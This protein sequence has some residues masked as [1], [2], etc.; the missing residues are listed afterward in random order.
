[1]FTLPDLVKPATDKD[2]NEFLTYADRPKRGII[3]R[4]IDSI[5]VLC[6]WQ[7]GVYWPVEGEVNAV[8]LMATTCMLN[9]TRRAA[10]K[11]AAVIGNELLVQELNDQIQSELDGL[12]LATDRDESE[13]LDEVEKAVIDQIA[14]NDALFS[15]PDLAQDAI[16]NFGIAFDEN[17]HVTIDKAIYAKA[18]DAAKP[19]L[20][21]A[22]DDE[23][24]KDVPS[25]MR[26]KRVLEELS[27][28]EDE[29][30]TAAAMTD[31]DALPNIS[32]AKRNKKRPLYLNNDAETRADVAE[33]MKK[34]FKVLMDEPKL[35]HCRFCDKLL[36][37]PCRN[38]RDL[39]DRAIDVKYERS[40]VCYEALK[41]I[42]GGEVGMQYVDL[43]RS[44][45]LRRMN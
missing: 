28:E 20:G 34:T 26:A 39:T 40:N 31:P 23:V 43:Q 11:A 22:N 19:M 30:I 18:M 2:G 45:A 6:G 4:W 5:E 42:G 37:Q 35:H 12:L 1:M 7:V 25:G 8:S 10:E 32:T 16:D 38:S 41:K 33:L 13:L 27:D 3:K 24:W 36:E 21:F 17:G 15:A 9:N 44:E 29:A 14:Q